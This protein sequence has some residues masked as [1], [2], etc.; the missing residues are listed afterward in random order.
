MPF[1]KCATTKFSQSAAI[2][3]RSVSLHLAFGGLGVVGEGSSAADAR[4]RVRLGLRGKAALCS[5]E[6][7]LGGASVSRGVLPL[8]VHSILISIALYRVLKEV[9]SIMYY[10]Y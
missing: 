7:R 8:S 5:G 4:G 3:S 1:L 2:G 10:L 9:V 6:P